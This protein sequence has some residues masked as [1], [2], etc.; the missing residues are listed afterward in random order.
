ME[1]SMVRDNFE[2]W[3][4]KVTRGD[5]LSIRCRRIMEAS[6]ETPCGRCVSRAETGS[7]PPRPSSSWPARLISAC[8]S[9]VILDSPRSLL[10]HSSSVRLGSKWWI[11]LLPSVSSRNHPSKQSWIIDY[12]SKSRNRRRTTVRYDGICYESVHL[13]ITREIVIC[14][15]K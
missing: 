1:I 4:K 10:S 9:Y 8:R 2:K 12:E 14:R 3:K 5:V 15:R 11:F 6:I 7:G 13:Y